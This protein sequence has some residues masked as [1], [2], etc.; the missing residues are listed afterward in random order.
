[1]DGFQSVQ[2]LDAL[3]QTN[4]NMLIV[5]MQVETVRA[6][7]GMEVQTV[8]WES[9]GGFQKNFKTMCI[10]LPQLRADTNGKS[11]IGHGTSATP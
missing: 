2:V 7:V 8:Q 4:W 5:E 10:L 6:V 3:P 1:M 11:G 9:F